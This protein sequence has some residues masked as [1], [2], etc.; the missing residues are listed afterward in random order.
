V[1]PWESDTALESLS[2]FRLEA[3]FGWINKPE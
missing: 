3:K 1:E 2:K